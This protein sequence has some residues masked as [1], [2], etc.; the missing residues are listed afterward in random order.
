MRLLPI[1]TRMKFY[2]LIL[3]SPFLFYLSGFSQNSEIGIL[4]GTSY[5][6]GE[7]NPSIQI[8]NEFNPSLG[9][10]YRK[11]TGKR[12][13]LRIGASY[14]R[15][16]AV[17]NRSSIELNQNKLVSFSSNLF[18]AYGVLEFNFIP[19]QI[20]NSTNSSFTPYVFIGA[21][22]F[23]VDP[24]INST[25]TTAIPSLGAVIAPSMPFGLGIKFDFINNLGLAIEWGVRKTLTDRIDGLSETYLEGYQL[26]NTQNNDWYS[27]V[28]I[29]LN[30]KILTKSDHCPG[31]IN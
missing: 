31:A 10:F 29:T 12:Y 2:T 15:L 19:Y 23:R 11:T 8:A 28:G 6:L 17:N 22:V 13:A 21:A 7:I 14:G 4:G 3:L 18:E 25:S 26:S 9:V 16:S 20:N 30:Y 1:I 24:K 5:Y 27:I